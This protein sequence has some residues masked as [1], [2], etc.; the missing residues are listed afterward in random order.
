MLLWLLLAS[1]IHLNWSCDRG[2][3]QLRHRDTLML[4]RCVPTIPGQPDPCIVQTGG[5]MSWCQQDGQDYVCCGTTELLIELLAGRSVKKIPMTD[6]WRYYPRNS[7]FDYQVV[8]RAQTVELSDE[9]LT[10]NVIT[11]PP[12]AYPPII[13]KKIGSQSLLPT[14]SLHILSVPMIAMGNFTD[15][16]RLA[17]NVVAV[18]D[19]DCTI[20]V[21]TGMPFQKDE[22]IRNL[23]EFGMRAAEV[24]FLVLTSS[25]PQFIG[26]L[27][28]FPH[29]QVV[30]EKLFIYQDHAIRGGITE[31]IRVETCS[32]NTYLMA[33][34]GPTAN[35][36]TLFVK[37]VPSMGTVAV[38]GAL[39]MHDD[40]ITKIDEDYTWN[41]AKII[42][43]RRKV[44]CQANW[45]IPAHAAAFPVSNELRKMANCE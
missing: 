35:S 15:S 41:S 18:R 27:N 7:H 22:L 4:M 21:D 17:T 20:V 25:L 44:I 14:T 2:L 11:T 16:L 37:N 26:N 1:Q 39:F 33:T 13:Y 3:T 28:V 6:Q 12:P 32:S 29:A 23:H 5:R 43:S 42:N 45:I 38:T 9:V 24:Q 40:S 10:N 36:V 8:V 30:V 19:G 31:N 34:P